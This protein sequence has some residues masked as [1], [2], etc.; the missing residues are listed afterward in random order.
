MADKKIRDGTQSALAP[1]EQIPA[2]VVLEEMKNLSSRVTDLDT[3]VRCL[4]KE[5]MERN[6][7]LSAEL[8]ALTARFERLEKE[9]CGSKARRPRTNV[10]DPRT[11]VGDVD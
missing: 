10:G 9:K 6:R 11:N 2:I 1:E 5:L 7:I 4:V 3:A 8:I